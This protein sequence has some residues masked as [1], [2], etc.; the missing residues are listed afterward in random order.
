[1]TERDGLTPRHA[2]TYKHRRTHAA[3]TTLQESRGVR[4]EGCE[5]GEKE[6]EKEKEG[7]REGWKERS[8]LEGFDISVAVHL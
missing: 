4:A 2:H 7:G 5:C 3:E 1:M 8:E 6:G